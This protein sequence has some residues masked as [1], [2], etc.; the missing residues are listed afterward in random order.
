MRMS[1]L[2]WG[3]PRNYKISVWFANSISWVPLPQAAMSLILFDTAVKLMMIIPQL[4]CGSW[5]YAAPSNMPLLG[6]LEFEGDR[7]CDRVK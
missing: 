6:Y 2:R 4:I 1:R 3:P 5:Q 7:E